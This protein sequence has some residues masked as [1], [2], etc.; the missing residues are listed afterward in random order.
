MLGFTSK[1]KATSAEGIPED[2][3]DLTPPQHVAIIMDGNGRWATKRGL[4]RIAGHKRGLNSVRKVTREAK[5]LGIKYL[6]LFAFSTENWLRPREEVH[7]LMDLFRFYMRRECKTLVA[8]GVRIRFIG[9]PTEMP[10]DIQKLMVEA[11]DLTAEGEV[12]TLV[13][14]LNY[15]SRAEIVRAAAR[16][17]ERVAAGEISSADVTEEAISAELTTSG[18]PDPDLI[19]RTSGEQRLSNF[20][21][22]QAAYTEFLFVD[23]HWPDFDQ[24]SL[25]Q[26]VAAY[27]NRDRRFGAVKEA[28]A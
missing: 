24:T 7:G 3:G 19:L 12:M 6:T 2:A 15:G 10:D 14:A 18:I 13:V 4:P 8:E 17:S 5:A 23:K 21:L 20:L 22:W 16:L 28:S 9:D 25:R 11:E 1:E 26:A 27:N